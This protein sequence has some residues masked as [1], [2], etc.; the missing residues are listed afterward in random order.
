MN[1]YSEAL[2]L[3][4]NKIMELRAVTPSKQFDKDRLAEVEINKFYYE[5]RAVDRIMIVLRASGC[6]H[7]GKTGGCSMCSHFNGT[8]QGER[9][10]TK[11]I[12]ISGIR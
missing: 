11:I 6:E 5:G 4:S 9:L 3:V 12:S 7:Y 8:V 1:E 2:E 10:Q